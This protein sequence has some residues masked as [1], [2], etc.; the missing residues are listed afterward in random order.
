MGTFQ[1]PS[2]AE[3]NVDD[4]HFNDDPSLGVDPC[5]QTTDSYVYFGWAFLSEHIVAQGEKANGFPPEDSKNIRFEQT[6]LTDPAPC[7]GLLL[8]HVDWFFCDLGIPMCSC[9]PGSSLR[10]PFDENIDYR[11][12]DST[13]TERPAYR[14]R[15]GAERFLIT[16]IN[17]PS[18]SSEAQSTIPVMWDKLATK[19]QL[20][21]F[22]HLPGGSNA[23]YFDGHVEFHRYPG[24]HPVTVS[25]AYL[26]SYL[27]DFFLGR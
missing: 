15:E 14:L 22:N 1:C 26:I 11:N 13:A 17:N 2:S 18:A 27:H 21:G 12:V 8:R 6:M 10:D 24:N 7:G 9:S 3:Y 5:A 4:F 20:D 19:V 25:Y 16:D 23:L